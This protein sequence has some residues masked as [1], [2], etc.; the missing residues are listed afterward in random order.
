M[1]LVWEDF[2]EKVSLRSG[3]ENGR[4]MSE[5]QGEKG[6]Q[7]VG[8]HGGMECRHWADSVSV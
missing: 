3:K 6:V 4:D 2:L 7:G 1:G 8:A 5:E